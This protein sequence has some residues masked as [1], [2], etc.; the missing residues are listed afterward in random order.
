MIEHGKK[1]IRLNDDRRRH[2]AAKGK[3][4]GCRVLGEIGTI[5]TDPRWRIHIPHVVADRYS[6][7]QLVTNL[8][9]DSRHW[10]VLVDK[11]LH[12]AKTLPAPPS[13]C[14]RASCSG[15]R[16]SSTEASR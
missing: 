14:S 8:L 7:N 16:A 6:T 2:L 13:R 5:V 3:I 12:M 1:G 15:V 9:I 11:S 10:I 4:L